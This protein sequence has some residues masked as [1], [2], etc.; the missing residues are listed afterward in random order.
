MAD[1]HETCQPI[2]VP[3]RRETGGGHYIYDPCFDCRRVS[4]DAENK[5][6][7]LRTAVYRPL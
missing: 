7:N 3:N 4:W 1:K 6:S 2:F 5:P